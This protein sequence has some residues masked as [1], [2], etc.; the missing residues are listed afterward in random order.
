MRPYDWD[1]FF[2]AYVL[3][4]PKENLF[5]S[6]MA[7]DILNISMLRRNGDTK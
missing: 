2:A 4:A 5:Q 1:K 7:F 6:R 3:T